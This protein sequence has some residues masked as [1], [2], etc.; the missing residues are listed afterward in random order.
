M[1]EQYT[2]ERLGE[3]Y[4]KVVQIFSVDPDNQENKRRIIERS[5]VDIAAFFQKN[6][7]LDS[8]HVPGIGRETKKVLVLILQNSVEEAIRIY[9]EQKEAE[10]RERELQPGSKYHPRSLPRRGKGYNST[11][12]QAARDYTRGLF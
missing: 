12:S 8:L 4:L 5:S 10:L 9:Q 2:N 1:S 7:S 6:R 11:P 3:Y